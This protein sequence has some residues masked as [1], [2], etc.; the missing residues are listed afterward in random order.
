MKKAYLDKL[1]AALQAHSPEETILVSASRVEGR[2]MLAAVAAQGYILVGVQ[3]E[4]P[5]S[6]ATSEEVKRVFISP[7]KGS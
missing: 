4:T 1:A 5:F 7:L 6:L 2:R 3:A